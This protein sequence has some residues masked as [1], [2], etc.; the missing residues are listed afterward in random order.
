MVDHQ[1]QSLEKAKEE[2]ENFFSGFYNQL[3]LILRLQKDPRVNILLKVLPIAALVYL[4]VP[5]DFLPVNPIDDAVV[6][7]LGGYLFIELCP[8]H[9]VDEHKVD[10]RKPI[11]SD[12]KGEEPPPDVI[13]GTYRDSDA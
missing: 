2:N 13:D 4:V 1:K 8:S 12:V 10:L 7:W 9:I 6:L 11:S 5:L 3:R